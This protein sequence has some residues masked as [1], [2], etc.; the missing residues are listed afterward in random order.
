MNSKNIQKRREKL[1]ALLR[2]I[3]TSG[4]VEMV[5]EIPDDT[6]LVVTRAEDFDESQNLVWQI[7]ENKSKIRD[8]F[9][10]TCEFQVVMSH[11]LFRRYNE[12]NPKPIVKCL[13]CVPQF[14]KK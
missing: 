11:G 9:C 2:G 6:V 7:H 14:L 5:S 8:I 10:S 1:H 12:M 3:I 4:A 13:R